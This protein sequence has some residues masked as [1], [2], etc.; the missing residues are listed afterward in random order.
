[1]NVCICTTAGV[2]PLAPTVETSATG[3]SGQM[4]F[5]G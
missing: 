1:M 5:V 4:M 3:E 2:M